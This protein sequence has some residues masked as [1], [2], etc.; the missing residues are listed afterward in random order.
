M[1]TAKIY[2]GEVVIYSAVRWILIINTDPDPV[3]KNLVTDPN[4]DPDIPLIWIRIH[5]KN[6]TDPDPHPK[7][8]YGSGSAT[9]LLYAEKLLITRTGWSLT[10]FKGTIRLNTVKY[11]NANSYARALILTCLGCL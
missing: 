8:V 7:N 11:L 1:N 5:V 6:N 2:F 10:D 3:F 9:L 4:P